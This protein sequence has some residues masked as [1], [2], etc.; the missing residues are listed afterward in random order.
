[1][2]GKLDLNETIK[3][4]FER[5]S[6]QTVIH[7]LCDDREIVGAGESEFIRGGLWISPLQSISKV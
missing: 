2:K 4:L 1:M 5:Q 7:L 3:N 6:L